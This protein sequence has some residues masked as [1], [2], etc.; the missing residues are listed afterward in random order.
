MIFFFSSIGLYGLIK[1]SDE[2]LY[3]LLLMS[4]AVFG[5]GLL[6]FIVNKR[7]NKNNDHDHKYKYRVN[8]VVFQICLAISFLFDFIDIYLIYKY[9]SQGTPLWQAR[10]WLLQPYGS[11]NP[12]LSRRSFIEEFFRTIVISPINSLFTPVACYTIFNTEQKKIKKNTLIALVVKTIL[13]SMSGGGGRLGI[14]LLLFC[15]IT[16]YKASLI[17]PELITKIKKSMPLIFFVATIT[18]LIATNARTGAGN[19][20]KQFYTYF[21][22]QPSLLAIWLPSI[23]E[24]PKTFGLTTM[25]G[26]H[27]YLFRFM[28]SLGF[29]TPIIYDVSYQNI[30][31]A[32]K[33][34]QLGFGVANAFV[35]PVYYFMLDGGKLFVLLASILLGFVA[36]KVYLAIQDNNDIKKY[37]YY[38]LVSTLIF[39]T[40]IR[41]QTAAPAFVVSLL[42]IPTIIKKEQI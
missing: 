4:M 38:Y 23:S 32:E 25:F 14:I 42:L 27:T 30:L 26:L 36:I 21:A 19:F 28:Q 7:Q 41:I 18:T 34:R 13:S 15:I 3:L 6:G 35:T 24:A 16:T 33:F 8:W 17:K 1:P 29:K 9:T 39:F 20:F 31:N 2:S 22:I 11:D 10:N 12:I 37:L 5:G 40:F